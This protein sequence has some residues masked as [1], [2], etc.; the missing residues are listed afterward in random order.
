MCVTKRM[1]F[2]RRCFILWAYD[3]GPAK[4]SY[5]L[6]RFTPMSY[7]SFDS[8]NNSFVK[9]IWELAHSCHF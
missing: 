9:L 7:V 2:Y 6:E 4:V 5:L 1:A 3:R 8:N